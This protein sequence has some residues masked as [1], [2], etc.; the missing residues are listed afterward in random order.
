M[1]NDD[2]NIKIYEIYVRNTEEYLRH[3]ETSNRFFVSANI[4]MVSVISFLFESASVTG[5]VI[6]TLPI[7]AILVNFL[8]FAIILTYR[9]L[10][11]TKHE[12]IQNIENSFST[13][14][15]TEELTKLSSQKRY[16]RLRTIYTLIPSTFIIIYIALFFLLIF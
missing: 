9:N 14:P 6:Y 1:K 13:Q 16:I 15:L 2:Q 3:F 7:I 12:V 10:N 5:E 8:W 11:S 4:L